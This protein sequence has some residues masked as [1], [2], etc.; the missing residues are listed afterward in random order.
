MV[1]VVPRYEAYLD[2]HDTG[3]ESTFH[4][5]HRAHTVRYWNHRRGDG[6]HY[7]F[8][9][10]PALERGGGGRIYGDTP[11]SSYIDNDY[12]F[13][14]LSLAAIEVGPAVRR[15]ELCQ[16]WFIHKMCFM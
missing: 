15:A 4:L 16:S 7:V 3:H 1:V 9:S 6:V 5:D 11:R 13:A 2:V 12:R 8:V 14:L 10:H